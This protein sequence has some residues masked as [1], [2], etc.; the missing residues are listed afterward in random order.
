M[1]KR[2][3]PLALFIFVLFFRISKCI[4]RFGKF[5]LTQQKI[6]DYTLFR[7]WGDVSLQKILTVLQKINLWHYCAVSLIID[8]E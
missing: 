8:Y 6:R 7:K 1:G 5:S 2:I 3:F 4:A